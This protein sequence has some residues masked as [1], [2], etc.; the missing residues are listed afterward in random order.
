MSLLEKVLETIGA[1]KTENI[2]GEIVNSGTLDEYL[3]TSLE[4]LFLS[5]EPTKVY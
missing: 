4:G 1:I 3:T 2:E 5:R